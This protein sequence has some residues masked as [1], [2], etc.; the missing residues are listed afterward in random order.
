MV[1]DSKEEAF[2]APGSVNVI[3][4]EELQD[5]LHGVDDI[6]RVLRQVP[7]VNIQEEEGY[8]LRPNIGVRGVPNERSSK[9][10]LMEDGILIA[11]APYSAPSA[12]YFPPVGRM[13]GLE[14]TKGPGLIKYGPYTT[15]GSLNLLSTPIPD[16]D[17]LN[18]KL[19]FGTDNLKKIY[20]NGGT[21]KKYGGV[22]FETYQ[23]ETDGF[24]D[25]DGGGDTGVDLE[26]YQFKFRLNTDPER[27]FYQEVEYKGGF[28]DQQSNETYLGLTDED[29][30]RTP[31]RRYAASQ[32]DNIDVDHVQHHVRHSIEF[33][34]DIDVT[35]LLYYNE[36]QR[37][38]Y[39]IEK[40]GG[41]GIASVLNDPATFSDELAWLRGEATSPDGAI[42]LRANQRDY[43]SMGIQSVL[44]WDFEV[45]DSVH[46]LEVGAR[47]HSDEEDRFQQDDGYRI[48]NA[49]L[50]LTDEGA[51]G[52]QANRIGSAD[53][54]SFFVQDTIE[55]DA[56]TLVPGLRYERIN[57]TREDFG[58]ED[59][60]RSGIALKRNDTNVDSLIPGLAGKFEV[61]EELSVYAGIHKG[62]SP[63]G[64]SS[65]D[66]VEEEES[67]N[68]ETGASFERNSFYTK[69]TFFYTDYEN[70]LGADTLS[71]GG[72]GSGDLFNGGE[73]DVLGVEFEL[74]YDLVEAHDAAFAVPFRMNY[75][76][77][78]AEFASSFDSDFFGDVRDGDQVPYIPEHQAF[79]SLGVEYLDYALYLEAFFSD[80]MQTAVG[81]LD[82]PSTTD[83]YAVFDLLAKWQYNDYVSLFGT[84]ENLF[85]REY[86]VA[87]R[88]AGARPGLPLTAVAGVEFSY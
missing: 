65:N 79:G 27:S 55:L 23:L 31:F 1:A 67:I 77:T 75:T 81:E 71:S 24:K 33:S 82:S 72:T 49:R 85:D 45:L 38:W 74:G 13:S 41:T 62:F 51:P 69:A 83:S 25:L 44:G 26:D 21:S 22:M 54:W 9:I 7:G 80:K 18:A 88:P 5:Q 36:T 2:R 40:V 78:D 32:L 48:E 64:P 52:S 47:F 70:L 59:P 84:V 6:H 63:P 35:T 30:G 61:N 12:Y 53:A 60:T 20:L 43:E 8:G 19:G 46:S 87:R 73:A 28:Y 37:N 16:E 66:D 50:V 56:F 17:S 4:E 76:F 15:G 34:E 58:K 86:V 29:F 57:Y 14:L 3:E 68:Y 10:T 39:K 42:A 11:P